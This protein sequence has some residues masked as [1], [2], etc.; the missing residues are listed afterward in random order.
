MKFGR[1]GARD[2][3][4]HLGAQ[5]D[6][7]FLQEGMR[8]IGP[9]AAFRGRRYFAEGYV[10][11]E[12]PSGVELRTRLEADVVCT[13][14]FTEPWLGTPKAALVVRLPISG[15][16]LLAVN[17][18][19]VNFSIRLEAYRAQLDTISRL[20]DAHDGAAIVVG[21]FNNWNRW[22]EAELQAFTERN[23]LQRS[24]FEPDW[25]SRHLGQAIDGVLQRGF[26][27]IE[28]LAIPTRRSDH[29]PLMLKL[30]PAPVS[31]ASGG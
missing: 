20:L 3:L 21:D 13:L 28:A 22:R 27:V 2:L 14:S 29:N 30:Q 7:V 1:E 16:T 9:R 11:A 12:G 4:D 8:S 5:S 10:T 15:F 31:A 26:D 25:R 18:H 6:L 17:L 19:A 23:G 24:R